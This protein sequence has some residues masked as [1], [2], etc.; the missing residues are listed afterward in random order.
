MKKKQRK[1]LTPIVLVVVVILLVFVVHKATRLKRIRINDTTEKISI[2]NGEY[3]LV[4]QVKD[5]VLVLNLQQKQAFCDGFAE[6]KKRISQK[7]YKIIV[8]KSK[9]R[10]L[11]FFHYTQLI[12]RKK[13]GKKQ[14]KESK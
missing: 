9:N 10:I 6:D 7:N 13:E 4:S 2:R 8:D 3:D 5:G 11:D 1:S 12:E 14:E